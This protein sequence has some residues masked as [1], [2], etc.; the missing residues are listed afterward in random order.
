M[1]WPHLC[2]RDAEWLLIDLIKI[3][4]KGERPGIAVKLSSG[5][6]QNR[7]SFHISLTALPGDHT[8]NF[9]ASLSLSV[10]WG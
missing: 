6:R 8:L 9:L 7:Q 4:W 3:N 2:P 10:K 1:S 5:L